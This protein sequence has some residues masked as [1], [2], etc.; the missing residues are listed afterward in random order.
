[1][2]NLDDTSRFHLALAKIAQNAGRPIQPNQ[3]TLAR[4]VF[5]TTE[6]S[7]I[8]RVRTGGDSDWPSQN[9]VGHEEYNAVI[10]LLTGGMKLA[11]C[12]A[13]LTNCASHDLFVWSYYPDQTRV[14]VG[15]FTDIEPL[16][17]PDKEVATQKL[18][19]ES[20]FWNFVEA[21]FRAHNLNMRVDQFLASVPTIFSYA[22]Y[23]ALEETIPK[24]F[25]S[26]MG[27]RYRNTSK[28][29]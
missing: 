27:V 6:Y 19:H 17:G 18:R 7:R 28:T 29:W 10:P 1:M 15:I 4:V 11:M 14:V 5:S 3:S 8:S 20:A 9:G 12:C 23:V 2:T 26:K 25:C 13:D 24:S 21:D 22:K 16:L